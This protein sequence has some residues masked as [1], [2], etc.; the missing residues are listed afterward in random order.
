MVEI[1]FKEIEETAV[2]LYPQFKNIGAPFNFY[3]A[4]DESIEFCLG[5]AAAWLNNG[6]L[7]VMGT[8]CGC[9]LTDIN[10]DKHACMLKAGHKEPHKSPKHEWFSLSVLKEMT[11]HKYP[12]M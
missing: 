11:T 10:G 12:F 5:Y 2:E 6:C 3:D 7:T 4:S 9:I 1:S 8:F